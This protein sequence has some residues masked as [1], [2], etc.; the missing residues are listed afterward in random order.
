MDTLSSGND[1][2]KNLSARARAAGFDAI[3]FTSADLAPETARAGQAWYADHRVQS[4]VLGGLTVGL[5]L[6]FV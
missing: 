6:A 5:I 3:G 2:K 1:L 4:A